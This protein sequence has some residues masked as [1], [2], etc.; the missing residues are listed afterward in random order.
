MKRAEGLSAAAP[1]RRKRRAYEKTKPPKRG[2]IRPHAS[3][4]GGSIRPQ[5]RTRFFR[6]PLGPPSGEEAGYHKLSSDW[7]TT[8][9]C[10]F[11]RVETLGCRFLTFEAKGGTCL[12]LGWALLQPLELF[13][14]T[15]GAGKVA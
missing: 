4:K 12:F 10:R 9:G 14:F 5:E 8:L 7:H 1:T 15:L 3:R 2:S 11:R 13:D 6:V